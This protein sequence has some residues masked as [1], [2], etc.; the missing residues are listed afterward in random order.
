MTPSHLEKLEKDLCEQYFTTIP[1][2]IS[3]QQITDAVDAFMAFLNEPEDIKDHIKFR[4]CHTH[5]RGDIGYVHRDPDDSIYNDSKDY[6]HYHDA[7]FDRYPEFLEQNQTVR[8]FI[9]KASPIWNAAKNVGLEIINLLSQ[10]Y[11]G[12][13]DRFFMAKE[14]HV[15]L[16]FIRYNWQKSQQN[17]AKPHFDAGSCTLAIAESEKGLRIGCNEASLKLVQHS[18]HE[19]IF[20][21]SSNFNRLVNDDTF[22]PAWHDVI[23]LQQEFVGKP[24]ARWAV[25]CFFEAEGMT[26]IPRELTHTCSEEQV[27]QSSPR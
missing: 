6:F 1:F 18:P 14:P 11:P 21:L 16:R 23:Q 27:Y 8:T 24:Y 26:A 25:V 5:R 7:I 12:L 13:A 10:R 22:K 3:R 19:A 20:F 9:E 17:L 4:V 2:P 15:I